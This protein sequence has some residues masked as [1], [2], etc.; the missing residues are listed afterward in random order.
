MNAAQRTVLITGATGHQGG[1]IAR[2]LAGKGLKLRA[3][4][5]HPTSDAAKA[6]AALGIEI[7]AGDFDDAASMDRALDGAWGAYSVQNTWEAGVEREEAQGKAFAK[8]ARAKGIEHFVYSSVASAHRKTG[9]PHFENKW[10][11]EQTVRELK[12]ASHV[13]I[14]PVFFMENLTSSW[15]LNG[16]KIMAAMKPETRLQM[17]AVEDIGALGARAFTNA[18]EMKGAEIDLAGDAKTMPE[19]TAILSRALGKPLEFVQL[20]IEAVR[21]NSADMA[22]MLEWFDRV[23]YDADIAGVARKYD[24]RPTTLEAWAKKNLHA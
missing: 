12:F 2:A 14:R 20:P 5:R 11:V 16:D 10:R 22:S 4:T 9:I 6:L 8:A 23:G 1:A 17:V 21:Q 18:S 3:M 19:A 15:F 7:V 24:L 13:I